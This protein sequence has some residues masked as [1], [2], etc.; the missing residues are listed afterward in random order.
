MHKILPLDVFQK[1]CP[2]SSNINI[3]CGIILY[4]PKIHIKAS[5]K[6]ICHL[7]MFS[8]DRKSKAL[9]PLPFRQQKT[10]PHYLKGFIQQDRVLGF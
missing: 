7:H 10:E 4:T 6:I 8:L 3:I 2:Y 9:Q 1:G 5:L